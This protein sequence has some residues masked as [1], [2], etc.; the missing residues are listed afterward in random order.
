M[1]SAELQAFQSDYRRTAFT[2]TVRSCERSR[3]GYPSSAELGNHKTR[4]HTTG[5]KCYHQ[6]CR[7]NDV[8]FPTL[9]SLRVHQK[10]HFR[11]LPEIPRMLKRK[12]SAD[13]SPKDAAGFEVQRSVRQSEWRPLDL[14]L[15]KPDAARVFDE[16]LTNTA[17]A[18]VTKPFI[19][20]TAH[21]PGASLYMPPTMP[22]ASAPPPRQPGSPKN[23]SLS[24]L[25]ND[26]PSPAPPAPTGVDEVARGG[27]M[28]AGDG[29]YFDPDEPSR[30][31]GDSEIASPFLLGRSVRRLRR[32]PA[33][34]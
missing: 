2:C 3:L 10:C 5:F 6:N 14:S 33:E 20:Y 25:L 23:S 11:E 31:S 28:A 13:G 18:L 22:S 7:Y 34:L 32:P 1:S 26:D 29:R 24:W 30:W 16:N 12:Y 8:G 21:P 19:S 15:S 9:R 4:L 17:P 27:F